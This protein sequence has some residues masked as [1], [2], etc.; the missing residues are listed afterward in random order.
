MERMGNEKLKGFADRVLNMLN[1]S[2]LVMTLVFFTVHWF[3]IL[4]T[5]RSSSAITNGLF[6]FAGIGLPFHLWAN[7]VMFL[8]SNIKLKREVA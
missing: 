4:W 5:L 2:V 1:V 7:I 3:S 8:K 6:I